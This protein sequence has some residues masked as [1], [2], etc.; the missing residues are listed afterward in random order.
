MKT[1]VIEQAL[2]VIDQ[3]RFL[4]ENQAINNKI[5]AFEDGVFKNLYQAYTSAIIEAGK[6]GKDVS[7]NINDMKK[8]YI[9]RLKDLKIPSIEPQ[10][11]CKKCNDTGYIDGKYCTCLKKEVNKILI[12]QSGFDKLESFDETKFDVFDNKDFMQKLY[13]KMKTWC[14]SKFDKTLI[15]IAGETGV[16]KTHLTKCMANELIN[17]NH[18]VL[19][20][21]SFAMHQDFVKSY[22][23][24]DLDEKS[25][26]L[27]RYLS[28]E[29][30]FIDDLGTE[31]R[32]PN[33]LNITIN[34]LYQVLNERRIKG[35]PTIITSNLD[36]YEI[37]DYYDERISSRIIDKSTSVCVF[38]KGEDIRLKKC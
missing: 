9:A 33:I 13:A 32:S 12:E 30:L 14:H 37:K 16:G 31:L 19:L 26:L 4:A 17:L 38:I 34:Y 10:F 20:T 3:K 2:K 11:F 8:K 24:K 35:L 29:V 1:T 7:S 36:L 15:F 25:A 23:T 21:S 28:S 27:D 18:I 6:E 5:K 22:S